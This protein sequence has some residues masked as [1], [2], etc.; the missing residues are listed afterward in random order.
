MNHDRRRYLHFDF[1]K[2]NWGPEEPHTEQHHTTEIETNSSKTAYEF[3]VMS[4][5]QNT[6]SNVSEGKVGVSFIPSIAKYLFLC[7]FLIKTF[8]LLKLCEE[9]WKYM[10]DEEKETFVEMEAQE[11]ERLRTERMTAVR[12]DEEESEVELSDEEMT[13]LT[14]Q[15][16]DCS[17]EESA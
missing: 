15:A 1:F 13:E 12:E 10:N 17:E 6:K 3:F 7:L 5:F 2:V 4:I 16:H 11:K 8:Q 9:K 14:I